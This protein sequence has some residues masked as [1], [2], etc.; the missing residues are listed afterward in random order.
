MI[1][2]CPGCARAAT[3]AG[4]K[5]AARATV[6]WLALLP[7]VLAVL[8]PKCPMRLVA[9]L[10]AFG[11]SL[12]V[13]TFALTVARLLAIGLAAVALVFAL[14]RVA[15]STEVSTPTREGRARMCG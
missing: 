12:G 3:D 13:A 4:G 8:A 11:V 5:S 10:S 7:S 6:Q 14:R 15:T 2:E 1:P 9:Y